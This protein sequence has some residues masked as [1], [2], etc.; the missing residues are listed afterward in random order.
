MQNQAAGTVLQFYTVIYVGKVFYKIAQP[1]Y[2]FSQVQTLSHTPSTNRDWRSFGWNRLP[3]LWIHRTQASSSFILLFHLV[4]LK[5]L[6]TQT[7]NVVA[8][9]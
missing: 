9:R 6:R 5:L 3:D 4:C 2:F 1:F 8:S 7:I